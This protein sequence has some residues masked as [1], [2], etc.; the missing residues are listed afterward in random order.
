VCG[1]DVVAETLRRTNLGRLAPGDLVNVER[2]LRVGDRVDGHFV[3]G[4]VDAVAQVTRVDRSR[5]EWIAR[6]RIEAALAPCIV[7]KGSIALDGTSMT[8]VD[9]R[10]GEFSVALIPT[11]IEKSLLGKRSAG[12]LVNVETDIIARTVVAYLINRTSMTE[13]HAPIHP[14]HAEGLA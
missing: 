3:Q 5:G 13:G 10:P 6:F 12:D 1:F 4:H 8:V 2:S 11:T 9:A 14:K 7:E